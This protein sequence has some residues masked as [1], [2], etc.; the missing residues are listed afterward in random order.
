MPCFVGASE[1]ARCCMKLKGSRWHMRCPK[2][3]QTQKTMKHHVFSKFLWKY[4]Y[5]RKGDVVNRQ[6]SWRNFGML[7]GFL[8]FFLMPRQIF[9]PIQ[10]G[11]FCPSLDVFW[12]RLHLPDAMTSVHV[13]RGLIATV[14]P[15]IFQNNISIQNSGF[16]CEK[17]WCTVQK[18]VLPRR[19]FWSSDLE[20]DFSCGFWLRGGCNLLKYAPLA[21]VML[22]RLQDCRKS[23]GMH[24]AHC[25]FLYRSCRWSLWK[26]RGCS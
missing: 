8:F 24:L 4:W 10:W 20:Q 26:P 7:T 13:Q 25:I 12:L 2:Q 11:H 16:C 18:K 21:A 14:F 9:I 22:A 15:T 1:A 19:F 3:T 5:E 17:T 23:V 6:F